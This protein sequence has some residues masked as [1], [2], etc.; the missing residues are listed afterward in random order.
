MATPGDVTSSLAL[1]LL[2]VLLTSWAPIW[3][4][5]CGLY[6]HVEESEGL[7]E[8]SCLYTFTAATFV[9]GWYLVGYVTLYTLAIIYWTEESPAQSLLT[10]ILIVYGLLVLFQM[11]AVCN[12]RVNTDLEYKYNKVR[13]E[14]RWYKKENPMFKRHRFSVIGRAKDYA[15]QRERL[16]EKLKD[17]EDRERQVEEELLGKRSKRLQRRLTEIQIEKNKIKDKLDNID[18]SDDEEFE[19][20]RTLKGKMKF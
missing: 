8:I 17:L 16:R 10:W 6:D 7:E 5:W 13:G 1:E 15:E 4:Y 12:R 19:T 20:A 2:F 3:I 18:E 11:I 14:D 9:Y